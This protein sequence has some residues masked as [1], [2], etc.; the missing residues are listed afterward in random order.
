MIINP[1]IKAG[2]IAII[3]HGITDI[4]ECP[5]K[6]ITANLIINPLIYSIPEIYKLGILFVTSIYHLRN[7]V[8][9][10][11]KGSYILHNIWLIKPETSIFYLSCIHTPRHYSRVF[12]DKIKIKEKIIS[13]LI[14][15]IIT[16]YGLNYNIDDILKV[17]LGNYWWSGPIVSHIIISETKNITNQFLR[18]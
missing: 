5:K 14:F 3:P 9:Y 11:I 17:Y 13:I 16:Y 18:Y 6:I 4:I 7:D 2:L 8:P 1:F 12:K 10:N 15:T